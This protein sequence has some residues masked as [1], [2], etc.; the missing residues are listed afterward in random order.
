VWTKNLQSLNAK[1]T[2][3]NE[4]RKE[5]RCDQGEKKKKKKGSFEAN[6]PARISKN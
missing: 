3:S 4:S 1:S 6:A 2:Q 5:E